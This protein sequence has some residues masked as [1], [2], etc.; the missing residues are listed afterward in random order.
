MPET[1][2]K[3]EQQWFVAE[4]GKTVCRKTTRKYMKMSAKLFIQDESAFPFGCTQGQT[5]EL[6]L[7]YEAQDRGARRSRRLDLFLGFIEG[8]CS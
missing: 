3:Q 5:P 8:F 1:S 7:G 4:T 6:V 2:I